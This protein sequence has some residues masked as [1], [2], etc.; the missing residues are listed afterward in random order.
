MAR[1]MASA[2]KPTLT[3]NDCSQLLETRIPRTQ[4]FTSENGIV[5]VSYRASQVVESRSWDSYRLSA[6]SASIP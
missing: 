6:A 2:L 1:R 3:A 5:N 4:K